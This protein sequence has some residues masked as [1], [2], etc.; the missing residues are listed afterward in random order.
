MRSALRRLLKSAALPEQPSAPERTKESFRHAGCNSALWW[1]RRLPVAD[2]RVGSGGRPLGAHRRL[3]K[4][5]FY[6]GVSRRLC[7]GR[8]ADRRRTRPNSSGARE[9]DV[10]LAIGFVT[11]WS[12]SRGLSARLRPLGRYSPASPTNL[13]QADKYSGLERQSRSWGSHSPTKTVNN[14]LALAGSASNYLKS[15]IPAQAGAPFPGRASPFSAK[16]ESIKY[17]TD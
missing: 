17:K 1:R 8:P 9:S 12:W 7:L 11:L 2:L 6:V 10:G 5:L 4:V 14:R 3:S 15:Q 13:G 16:T